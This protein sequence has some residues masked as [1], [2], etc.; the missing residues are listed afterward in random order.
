MLTSTNRSERYVYAATHT[1]YAVVLHIV[2][3]NVPAL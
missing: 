1:G 2:Y 3:R